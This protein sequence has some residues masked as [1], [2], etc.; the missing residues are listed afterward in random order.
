MNVAAAEGSSALAES[1]GWAAFMRLASQAAVVVTEEMPVDPEAGSLQV[2]IS[3]LKDFP[4]SHHVTFC[5]CILLYSSALWAFTAKEN[6]RKWCLAF[7]ANSD[8]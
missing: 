5:C 3:F 6:A 1:A 7:A 4:T 2:C 8:E